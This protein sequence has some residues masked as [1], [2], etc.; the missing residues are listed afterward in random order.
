MHTN[1]QTDAPR[2]ASQLPTAAAEQPAE[3][4]GQPEGA[5]AQ[6]VFHG[7]AALLSLVAA[8]MGFSGH[9]GLVPA[10]GAAICV[11]LAHLSAPAPASS[12]T[13]G[14]APF[15]HAARPALGIVSR[16]AFGAM[17]I[18][19]IVGVLMLSVG[20]APWAA[21][22]CAAVSLLIGAFA[23]PDPARA[24]SRRIRR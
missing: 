14:S 1:G 24:T 8:V 23:I 11:L 22:V 4:P 13:T 2:A 21:F 20:R 15:P 7:L 17:W 16:L 3:H 19:L 5:L 18:L 6:I 9:S 12:R 10:I